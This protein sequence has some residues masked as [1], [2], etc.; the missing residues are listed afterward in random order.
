MQETR[1]QS[2]GWEDILE[3]GTENF[4]YNRNQYVYQWSERFLFNHKNGTEILKIIFA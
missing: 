1:V 4:F 2:L 3:K